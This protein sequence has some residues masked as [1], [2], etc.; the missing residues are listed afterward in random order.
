MTGRMQTKTFLIAFLYIFILFPGCAPVNHK[1]DVFAVVDG[2]PVMEADLKY[3]LQVAHRREDLSNASALDISRYIRK[4]I[5]DRLITDE[6]RRMGMEQYPEVREAVR[7]FILRESVSRLYNE[8]IVQRIS[9]SGEEIANYYKKNY[10]RFGIIEAKAETDAE[11][12]LDLLRKGGDFREIARTLSTHASGKDGGEVIYTIHSLKPLI[13]ETLSGLRP[14]QNSGILDVEGKYYIL[15]LPG[16]GESPGA[17]LGNIRKRIE[18]TIHAEKQKELEKSYQEKLREQAVIDIDEALLADIKLDGNKEQTEKWSK[19]KRPLARVY[20]SVLSV[21]DF[22][23]MAL[24]M[25]KRNK[26]MPKLKKQVIDNW[27]NYKV[28]DHEALVR[29]YEVNT[30]LKGKVSRYENQLLKKTFFNNVIIPGVVVT[31]EELKDYYIKHQEDFTGP[32]MIRIQQITVKT[33]DEARNIL[34]SLGN[35][36]D[37]SWLA[38]QKSVDAAAGNGGDVGWLDIRQLP[39]PER[40]VAGRTGPGEI[41]PAF[42]VDSFFRIIRVQNRIEAEVRGFG[43]VKDDI[44]RACFREQADN[45]MKTYIARLKADADIKIHEDVLRSYEKMLKR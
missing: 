19:D 17:G 6:A 36:A 45:L 25:Y 16:D 1:P 13:K 33:M 35:G 4:L 14:G 30:D 22:V 15:N 21:G 39:E 26:D 32:E 43:E 28:I 37:F 20:S 23:S 29:R 31:D 2:S 42:A 34:K 18:K 44:Y 41:S 11:G 38:G 40:E 27:I 10:I 8:E 24:P 12:I 7:A 5:D 3:A 9:V